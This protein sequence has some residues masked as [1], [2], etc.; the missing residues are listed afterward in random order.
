MLFYDIFI[1]L[2][3]EIQYIWKP[4]KTVVSYLYFL[5]RYLNS[6]FYIVTMTYP[7]FTSS[8]LRPVLD[9]ICKNLAVPPA[10][11]ATTN[12]FDPD[13]LDVI[14]LLASKAL[15]L[16]PAMLSLMRFSY[17]AST[18]CGRTFGWPVDLELWDCAK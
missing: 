5:N 6:C 17:C 15:Q 9:N 3:D 2:D 12:N 1:T 16:V 13:N 14:N 7:P 4:K 11:L 18:L 8:L 10:K